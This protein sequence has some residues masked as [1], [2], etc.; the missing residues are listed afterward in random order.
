MIAVERD[1]YNPEVSTDADLAA[2]VIEVAC[3]GGP[4]LVDPASG[5]INRNGVWSDR[6]L[7]AVDG[8]KLQRLCLASES[9]LPDA[10][11]VR[12]RLA[13]DDK[14][15]TL[16]GEMTIELSGLF[17]NTE[18]LR[19]DEQK[20][21]RLQS[22]VE[23]IMPILEVTEFSVSHLSA[24]QLS[25]HVSVKSK[26]EPDKVYDRRMLTLAPDTPALAEAHL[27]LGPSMRR[28]PIQLPGL[29]TDDVSLHIKLPEG[30]KAVIL[31]RPLEAVSGQWGRIAQTVE[32]KDGAVQITRR[33]SF[34]V[35]TIQP[36]DYALLRDAVRALR[37]DGARSIVL[38]EVTE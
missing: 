16:T 13:L 10:V 15:E 18:E 12:G 14:A 32:P 31:P 27:P 4:L 35:R 37:S 29:L 19:T 30:F 36:A 20:K 6:D 3:P 28:T 25:A 8:G 24:D 2:V 11:R 34:D 23:G 9:S 21:S 33:V 1:Q 26:E 38:E 17:V 7:L 5:I 22:I